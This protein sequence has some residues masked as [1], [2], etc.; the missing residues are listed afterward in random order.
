VKDRNGTVLGQFCVDSGTF[1]V[2]PL[3]GMRNMEY[4]TLDEALELAVVIPDFEGEIDFAN[5]YRAAE[6]MNQ[7]GRR[8]SEGLLFLKFQASQMVIAPT[9]SRIYSR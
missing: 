3:E 2:F 6:V 8:G 9:A 4:N 5:D 7:V 1:G